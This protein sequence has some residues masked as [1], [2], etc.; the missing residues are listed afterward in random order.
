MSRKKKSLAFL[1]IGILLLADYLYW[2]VP[3]PLDRCL[4]EAVWD[5]TNAQLI[6]YDSFFTP[7]N[8]EVETDLVEGI[9]DAVKQTEVTRR[10]RSGTMSEPFC[11]LYLYYPDGYTRILV[12]QNGNI[13]VVPDHGSDRQ[14][15]FDG[16]EELYRYLQNSSLLT[17]DS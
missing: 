5:S 7:R 8:M 12:V 17:P 10:P 14:F 15:Y 13:S 3:I 1:V 16:G 9:L 2:T 11:Y 6:C 4:P